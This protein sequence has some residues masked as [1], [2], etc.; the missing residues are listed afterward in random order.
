MTKT[1]ALSIRLLKR[2]VT[3]SSVIKKTK[4]RPVEEFTEKGCTLY[5]N[6]KKSPDPP[7]WAS[8]LLEIPES[9]NLKNKNSS[10]LLFVELD[11]SRIMVLSFGSGF[12]SI[13][14]KFIEDNFGLITTLNNVDEK[15]LLSV[16]LFTPEVNSTQKRVQKG[17][18]SKV[19]EFGIN[20]SKEL[21]KRITGISKEKDF[22]SIMTGSDSLSLK[23]DIAKDKIKEKCEETM[24]IYS[25]KD[26]KAN[27]GWIDNVKVVR[28]EKRISSLNMEV[29]KVLNDSLEI[30]QLPAMNLVFPIIV[31]YHKLGNIKFSGFRYTTEFSELS[32][33]NYI[34]ALKKMKIGKI[35]MSDFE[36]HKVSYYNLET[37]KYTSGWPI[38][39][40]IVSE[41]EFEDNNYVSFAGKW[42]LID[43][44]YYKSISDQVDAIMTNSTKLND[45]PEFDGT[46]DNVTKKNDKTYASENVYNRRVANNSDY[47]LM[48]CVLVHNTEV[49]DLISEEKQ[50][51]HVK[52]WSG[53][54]TL[55]HLFNQ[56]LVSSQ[57]FVDSIEYRSEIRSKP[58]AGA[59]V[60]NIF[61]DAKPNAS[62]F[63]IHFAI[64]DG[65]KSGKNTLPF[66][67]QVT[68]INTHKILSIQM[69]FNM[70]VWWIDEKS[71]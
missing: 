69:N 63:A 18:Y 28:D 67:S 15:T 20:Q 32:L 9:Y 12:M 66:F 19:N 10:A 49:C 42:Y 35:E 44:D 43:S 34:T 13:K 24:T 54:S 29:L 11:S 30:N 50:L 25:K 60:K 70:H 39:K 52:R 41:I 3:I 37:D 56:G 7:K 55:S 53:S 47:I 8:E 5:V 58:S 36:N 31:D 65:R 22:S 40:C 27:F 21:L 57:T 17:H 51:I 14:D 64:I 26:Y 33:E 6:K 23:C 38:T 46:V 2:G 71:A 61:T 1:W 59:I 16:D 68:L 4:M 48:D 45:F 62:D